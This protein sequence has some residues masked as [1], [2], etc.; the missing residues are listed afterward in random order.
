MRKMPV[1]E[2]KAKCLSVVEKVCATGESVIVT[3]HGKPVVRVIPEKRDPESL[4]DS[5][6]GII[7]IRGDIVSPAVDPDDWKLLR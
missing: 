2:F 4:F 6:K 7:E 5:M 1:S 3:K